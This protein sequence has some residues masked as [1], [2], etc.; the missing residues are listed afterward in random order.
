MDQL[1]QDIRY[2]LRT[3]SRA[4]GFTAVAILTLAIGIG[5]NT[6]I[7]S[8]VH[9]VLLKPLPYPESDRLVEVLSAGY[10]N[11]RFG[12]SYPDLHDLRDMTQDFT[13]VGASTTQRYNLTGAGDPREVEAASVTADLFTVL[14]VHPELGRLFTRQDE[15]SPMALIGHGL[16][17]TN[18]GSDRGIIG[19]PIALDGKSYTVIGVM[20]AG[21]HFPDRS[22]DV[23]TPV[24]DALAQNPRAETERGYH[25]FTAVARLQPG[26]TVPRVTADL[27]VLAARLNAADSTAASAGG[28]VRRQIVATGAGPVGPPPGGGGGGRGPR[29]GAQG[30][31]GN[32]YAAQLL[33]DVDTGDVRRPLFIMLGAVGL[34]LLIAC[35]N[36]AN[37]L[38]ARAAARRREMAVRRALGAARSR[39]VLQLLTESVILALAAGLVGVVLASWGLNLLLSIW[40]HA[41]PRGG[42]IGLDLPV[43]VFTLGL[44]VVTGIAFGSVPAWRASAPGIEEALREDAAGATGGRRHRLQS[45]LV[46]AEVALSLVLLVGAGLLVRSFIRLSNV[47][48]GFDTR[49][50]IAARIRLTP[51]RYGNS[52]AQ[53]QFFD[54][55][56]TA[57]QG[58]PGVQN[59]SLAGTL[60]LSGAMRM[61]AF[62]P[63]SVRPDYPQ[64]FMVL[65]SFVVSPAYFSAFRIPLRE[66][67]AFTADDRATA[68]P[69]A[70]MNRDA[71]EQ[72]WPNQDPVGKQLTIGR[73]P[74]PGGAAP[75]PITIVGVIDN[76]RSASLDAKPQPEIYTPAAQ[77]SRLDEMWV[78][79]R[80]ANGKP[81]Q[82]TGIIRN[83]VRQADPEQPIGEI[84]SLTELADQL[85]AARRFNTT[86]LTLFALLAMGLALVGIYGV[87][88]YAVTQRT[89][90][91]G[92]RLALG[93]QPGQVVDLLVRENLRRVTIGVA[94]G[95]V[96]ALG[97]ARVLK[98][99][100]YDVAPSD[101]L[102]FG[103]TAVLLAG[104]A[105]A[106]TW[107]PARRATRVDPMTA[108]RAE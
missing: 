57:L 68:P 89:R 55:L 61:L 11:T 36:A 48:P 73:G 101:A 65:R 76:L 77:E 79:F 82:M 40:P 35:A 27:A 2:A 44:A 10:Q 4:P 30:M 100:L 67:R 99:L 94:L 17:V 24:G 34:V 108:L 3:L 51:T 96:A 12:V 29:N 39:L 1:F 92:I 106:A 45:G 5:A 95:L 49:D 71:A 41:L 103:G 75:P 98:A 56:L 81:L 18:F 38:L 47:N 97:A 86:L 20:P 90:E 83:A 87:T 60:P 16:W 72:L 32:G 8:A 31:F 74:S 80:A 7:F 46:I 53:S 42:E 105:L 58:R 50:L 9:T 6:A 63:R 15:R 62:D 93:A 13:G 66:G 59:A 69:V 28:P 78:V 85:T 104:V 14:Q 91:L 22:I 26:I 33:R 23:W 52:P 54:N 102:T 21:F 88:A 43:L 107:W 84:A 37:L 70:I 64:P 19:K 25:F